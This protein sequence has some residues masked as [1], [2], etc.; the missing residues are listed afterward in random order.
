M[1]YVASD[2]ALPTL[3]WDEARPSFHVEELAERDQAVRRQFSK[4]CVYY[5]GSHEGCGCGSQYSASEGIDEDPSELS[6]AIDSRR[7]LS[8]FL[9]VALQH[10]QEVELFACW[11]GDQS[12]EPEHRNR[13]RPA[14]LI[15]T[16]TDFHEKELLVLTEW[17]D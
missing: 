12:A 8:E 15:R 3:T 1:V 14:D 9:A 7:R 16:R 10:Q 11:D 4:P 13:L 2:Y 17:T 5:V 6:A